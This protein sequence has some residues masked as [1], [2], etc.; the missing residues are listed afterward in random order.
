MNM[1]TSN[2]QGFN[3]LSETFCPFDDVTTCLA[4]LSSMPLNN[5]KRKICC[6]TEKFDECPIFLAEVL[7]RG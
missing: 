3:R 1:T 6:G 4:S 2:L 7:R 5:N